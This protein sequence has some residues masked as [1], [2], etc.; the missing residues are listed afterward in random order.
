MSTYPFW[1]TINEIEPII[2][3]EFSHL[4]SQ[5]INLSEKTNKKMIDPNQLRFDG[6]TLL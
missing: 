4:A 1:R 6:C 3:T 5:Q 2:I